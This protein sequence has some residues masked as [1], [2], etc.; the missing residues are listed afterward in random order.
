MA[1]QNF[2]EFAAERTPKVGD[3]LYH[4]TLR[5]NLSKIMY[6]GLRTSSRYARR[7]GD[8]KAVPRLFVTKSLKLATNFAGG[9]LDRSDAPGIVVSF[10]LKSTD[11]VEIY[12]GTPTLRNTVSPER[13]TVEWPSDLKGKTAKDFIKGEKVSKS[14]KKEVIVALNAVLRP[15]GYEVKDAGAATPKVLLHVPLTL[16]TKTF[17]ANGIEKYVVDIEKEKG[18]TKMHVAGAPIKDLPI[19][20]KKWGASP[21]LLKKVSSLVKDME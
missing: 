17:K 7:F 8:E 6:S 19:H 21:A 5:A 13:I 12:D 10:K 4:G 3:V 14:Q 18:K 1:I 15:D 16:P 2:Q 9:T 20:L 11:V